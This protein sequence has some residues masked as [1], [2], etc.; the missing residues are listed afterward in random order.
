MRYI[1]H[2]L[3]RLSYIGRENAVLQD[4]ETRLPENLAALYD[5]MLEECQRG[6]TD[7]QYHALKKLFAWVAYS[8]RALTL[9]EASELAQLTVGD[10]KVFDIE[11]ELIGRSAR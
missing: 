10:E 7:K 9:S 2:M 5:L 11:D 4:L 6:R 3:R 1:E 8:K